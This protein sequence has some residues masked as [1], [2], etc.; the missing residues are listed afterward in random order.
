MVIKEEKRAKENAAA[1]AKAEKE[2][3]DEAARRAVN[4][5]KPKAEQE[6][7][8]TPPGEDDSDFTDVLKRVTD[9]LGTSRKTLHADLA[10]LHQ[11]ID[12]EHKPEHAHDALA[13]LDPLLKAAA[14]ASGGGSGPRQ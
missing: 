9:Q 3:A 7:E 13:A 2:T 8:T 10:A 1:K 14:A 11:C 6:R 5:P 12:G 4:E